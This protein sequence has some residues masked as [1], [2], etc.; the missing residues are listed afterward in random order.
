MA[1][2]AIRGPQ[3]TPAQ[4]LQQW[5]QEEWSD[6][7]KRKANIKL[8]RALAVFFGGESRQASAGTPRA[9]DGS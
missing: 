9:R 3:Q 7:A 2:K 4:M 8:L 6:P 1:L 5:A